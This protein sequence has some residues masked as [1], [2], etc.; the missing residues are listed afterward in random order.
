MSLDSTN[1]LNNVSEEEAMTIAQ[2]FDWKG[3][4]Q[5]VN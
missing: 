2:K 1:H 5:L 3:I 4:Q